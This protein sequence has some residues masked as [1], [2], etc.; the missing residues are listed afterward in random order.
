[1][2]TVEQPNQCDSILLALISSK[3]RVC[4]IELIFSTYLFVVLTRIMSLEGESTKMEAV[5]SSVDAQL[6]VGAGSDHETKTLVS[7][8]DDETTSE[9]IDDD[10]CDDGR[11]K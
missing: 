9:I 1:M 3:Q 5:A 11:Y 10:D 7:S 4:L 2:L 8:S 6:M